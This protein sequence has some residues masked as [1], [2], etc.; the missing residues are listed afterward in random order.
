MI[1][2]IKLKDPDNE[3]DLTNVTIEL[4]CPES[5]LDEVLAVFK[6]FAVAIGYS[7][8]RVAEIQQVEDEKK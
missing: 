1:R 8:E 5:N 3:F 4:P 6:E 2:F 7:P